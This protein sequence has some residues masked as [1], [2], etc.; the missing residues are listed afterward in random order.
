MVLLLA[1]TLSSS[2]SSSLSYSASGGSLLLPPLV[3]GDIALEPSHIPRLPN[4]VVVQ[5]HELVGRLVERALLPLAGTEAEGGVQHRVRGEHY[6]MRDAV[7]V[8]RAEASKDTNV[9]RRR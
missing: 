7:V 5:P 1:D 3:R 4:G 8:S 6:V 9:A 2:V